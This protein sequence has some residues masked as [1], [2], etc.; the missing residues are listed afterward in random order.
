MR[1]VRWGRFHSCILI[2][3]SLAPFAQ[4][5]TYN[6]NRT[7]S[8]T[9]QWS[10]GANWDAIPVSGTDTTLTIGLP[11]TQLAAATAIFTNNDIAGDFKLNRLNFTYGSASFSPRPVVT[12]SGNR[13]EFV[14]DSSGTTPVLNINPGGTPRSL[15]IIS[16]PL[17]LTN[18]LTVNNIS[19]AMLSGVISGPGSLATTSF[20]DLT[21]SGA[22]TY[23]GGTTLSGGSPSTFI[24]FNNS[25]AIGTGTL[26]INSPIRLTNTSGNTVTLS[27]NNAQIWA[28]DFS[29]FVGSFGST[30]TQGLNLGTGPVTLTGNRIVS[31]GGSDQRVLTVGGAIGDGGSGFSLTK[32][33]GGTLVLTGASTY[34]GGTTIAKGAINT[35]NIGNASAAGL[36]TG[37]IT[38]GSGN[39]TATLRY[40]GAGETTD[41]VIT[42][43]G[44]GIMQIDRSF[45][46]DTNLLKFTSDLVVSGAGPKI[47]ALTANSSGINEFAGKITG[48]DVSVVK[49]D[50]GTWVLSGA[51]TFTTKV[52]INSGTLSVSSLNSVVGGS[53]SSNLGA[54]ATVAAGTVDFGGG[55]NIPTVHVRTASTLQYT[56][57]GETTDRVLNLANSSGSIIEQAGSGLL[58]FTSSV[59]GTQDLSF[60][61]SSAGTGEFAGVINGGRNV[62]KYGTGTWTVSAA[63]NYTGTTIVYGGTLLINGNQSAAT[64][65]VTV[66]NSGTLGG[67]GV[68][69]GSVTITGG[70]ITAA[71]SGSVGMLTLNSNATFNGI[72]VCQDCDRV[73]GTAAPARTAETIPGT[74]LVDLGGATS[75]K[76]VI[77]GALDLSDSFDQ[78]LFNG[79]PDGSTS[80]VLAT[81]SSVSG[82]FDF[83]NAP[84][85]YQLVYGMNQLD[86]VPV[87]EP[88]TFLAGALATAAIAFLSRRSR[89]SHLSAR[90]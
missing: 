65:A 85:G 32:Q 42:L 38:I 17:L 16:A 81:Y 80:Y 40:I 74:Y 55:P 87:P 71:Q 68:I 4:G 1:R 9:D 83:G 90:S 64:G 39:E 13:L 86:L 28:S 37:N 5:A 24:H 19:D 82:T 25:S 29:F 6:Y 73:D 46:P 59:T 89:R 30:A 56:G 70:T 33:D 36:G 2:G 21:L 27:T 43:A 14:N 54:P 53:A 23:S 76:L 79:T 78:I 12:I 61:G 67:T 22:N 62:A 47:L 50:I 41:K 35:S 77:G 7:S 66:Y 49:D 34:S 57:T 8:G 88:G 18:N 3:L 69:G 44:S 72:F 51:N 10:T 11:A 15:L 31:V 52:S 45:G 48:S 63:N 20:G 26:T 60:A 75:D 58:K 84:S